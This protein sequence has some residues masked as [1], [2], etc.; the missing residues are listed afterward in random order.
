MRKKIRVWA[1]GALVAWSAISP[2]HA[3]GWYSP[4]LSHVSLFDYFLPKNCTDNKYFVYN[5]YIAACKGCAHRNSYNFGFDEGFAPAEPNKDHNIEAWQ[6]LLQTRAQE[7]QIA[8]IVYHTGLDTLNLLVQKL[9]KKPVELPNDLQVNTFATE[10]VAQKRLDIAKYLVYAKKCEPF[11]LREWDWV[12]WENSSKA[13]EAEREQMAAVREEGMQLLAAET[14]IA[15]KQRYLYQLVRLN[16][17]VDNFEQILPLTQEYLRPDMPQNYID[18]RLRG[19]LAGAYF[20]LGRVAESAHAYAM[21]YKDYLKTDAAFAERS[22]VNFRTLIQDKKHFEACVN[23]SKD[24]QERATVWFLGSLVDSYNNYWDMAESE[25]PTQEY[26][27]L[28][29]SM[30]NTLEQIWQNS[31]TSEALE[32]SLWRN[33][34]EVEDDYYRPMLLANQPKIDTTAYKAADHNITNVSFTPT[35]TEKPS[36]FKRMGKVIADIWHSILNWFSSSEK[37]SSKKNK[38]SGNANPTDTLYADDYV[39]PYESGFYYDNTFAFTGFHN[40]ADREARE[41]YYIGLKSIVNK[42]AAAGNTEQPALWQLT[43]AYLHA[44]NSEWT[45]AQEAIE[46]ARQQFKTKQGQNEYIL[47]QANL[48]EQY[49][50]LENQPKITAEYENKLA[51]FLTAQGDTTSHFD[52]IFFNRLG[53]KYLAQSEWQK[54]AMSYHRAGS[55]WAVGVLLDMYATDAQFDALLEGVRKGGQNN[56]ERY[57]VGKF[58][59]TSQLAEIKAVRLARDNHFTE[60]VATLEDLPTSYWQHAADTFQAS[61]GNEFVSAPYRTYNHLQ[62]FTT[63]DSLRAN[64]AA[65]PQNAAQELTAVANA[66][67]SSAYWGYNQ[68]LWRGDLITTA[69]YFDGNQYPLNVSDTLATQ[70]Y[71]RKMHFMNR[72]GTSLLAGKYYQ[73]VAQTTDNELGA[74][75]CYLGMSL[76]KRTQTTFHEGVYTDDFEPMY[77]L[78]KKIFADKPQAAPLL[79]ECPAL[80]ETLPQQKSAKVSS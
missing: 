72:Y 60:A 9:E 13:N 18:S 55:A 68:A 27:N 65:N 25:T 56:L 71:V 12:D 80:R 53:Q 36:F 38:P 54:A 69:R 7:T 26:Q 74:Q 35:P 44:M 40:A 75:A 23:L 31:P 34:Q 48:L 16:Y 57:L 39:N 32:T 30:L 73:K 66:L 1:L 62:F 15:L 52:Q 77:Q 42:I 50:A 3:C 5:R 2:A 29:A 28:H 49:V 67:W 14:N 22:Y 8:Q 4:Q 11:A 33:L 61:L 45:Q 37:K 58:F 19:R 51:D 47:L 59:N 46:M 70:F 20:R 64:A 6:L 63:I 41:D 43:K 10:I 24:N 78:W 17:F 21:I 79:K 76:T